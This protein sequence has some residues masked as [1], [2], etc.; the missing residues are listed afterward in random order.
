MP[1]VEPPPPSLKDM[2]NAVKTR[3]L[4]SKKTEQETAIK[5]WVADMKKNK[6]DI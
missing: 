6:K 5:L 1:S 3:H 4:R 2:E